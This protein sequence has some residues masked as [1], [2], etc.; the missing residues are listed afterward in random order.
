[1]SMSIFCSFGQAQTH[2]KLRSRY[3]AISIDIFDNFKGHFVAVESIMGS[4]DTFLGHKNLQLDCP[5][6]TSWDLVGTTLLAR[7]SNL[8]PVLDS[9]AQTTRGNVLGFFGKT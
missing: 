2:P 9:S 8:R 7:I 5:S 3:L 1:M 6:V 4:E